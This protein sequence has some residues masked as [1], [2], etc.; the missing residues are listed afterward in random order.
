MKAYLDR[1]ENDRAIVILEKGKEI[2]VLPS[3]LL[4]R[5]CKEGDILS[6]S[7]RIEKSELNKERQSIKKV[8]NNLEDQN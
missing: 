5:N 3:K 2:I 7:V 1:F 6:I 4:P 8:Q